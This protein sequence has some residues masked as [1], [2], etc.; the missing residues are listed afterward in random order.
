ME[1]WEYGGCG[2][3]MGEKV[4]WKDLYTGQRLNRRIDGSEEEL[5]IRSIYNP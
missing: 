4:K 5:D 1:R 2:G 3:E